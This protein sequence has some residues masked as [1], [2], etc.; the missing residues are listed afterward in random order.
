[1]FR[2]NTAACLLCMHRIPPRASF[3]DVPFSRGMARV[4]L[5]QKKRPSRLILSTR[6][7]DIKQKPNE[8]GMNQREANLPPSRRPKP[9][10]GEFNIGGMNRRYA[11]LHPKDIARTARA[12]EREQQR[13]VK[14]RNDGKSKDA[15]SRVNPRPQFKHLKMTQSLSQVSRTQ[16]NE[17]GSQIDSVY[18]FD[19]F[20]LLPTIKAAIHK[21]VL[22][23]LT[24]VQPTPVQKLVIPV[25]LG[26][27]PDEWLNIGQRGVESYLIAAETGSGK[28]LSYLLPTVDFLK[29]EEEALAQEEFEEAVKLERNKENNLFSLTPPIVEAPDKNNGKPRAVI[30]VPTAELVTQVGALVKTLSH[31]VKYRSAMISREFT[32]KVIRSRLFGSPIDVLVSTP[33]LLSS[34]AVNDPKVLSNCSHIIV[35]E[36]DSL[37][38]RSFSPLTSSIISR[39]VNLKRL[40]LCSATIPRSLDTRLRKIYPNIERLVTPNL[41]AIPRRVQLAIV[42]IDSEPYR[43]NKLLACADTLY[44]I[45]KDGSEE[46]FIKKV[47]VFVNEREKAPEVA[48][49]LRSKGLDAIE[50]E[51]DTQG[52]KESDV[53]DYFTGPKDAA[54][55]TATGKQRMRVLVTTDIAS[56][57]VDTKTVKNVVLYDVPFS[58]VDFIH[59]L[60]RTGRMGRRGR[61]VILVDRFTNKAWI[62]EIKQSMH[63]G[64][65]LI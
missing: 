25:L 5:A 6:V 61:A 31:A 50:L 60:G 18:S 39:A 41:H 17:I 43:G 2:L 59:R 27:D 42:D 22:S 32:G 46:G 54:E 35:D 14:T 9:D 65:P 63:I 64:G 13:D 29:R 57:G 40:I 21:E 28:T 23:D 3:R 12:S 44:N 15:K 52:R 45:A 36:A 19:D 47:I 20:N 37:F 24:T 55:P 16:R 53:L 62:K 4:S 11:N 48:E 56:R 26:Q 34:I 49:Y 1:M 30:L 38:D 58:T 10:D 7:A 51:R 8:G 33:H